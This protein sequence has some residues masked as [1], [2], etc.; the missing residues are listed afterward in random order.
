MTEA[1]G[2][3]PI[4]TPTTVEES[5]ARTLWRVVV[6]PRAAMSGLGRDPHAS[7]KGV[8]LLAIVSAVYT[9]ILAAFLGQGYAAAAP[10]ALPLASDEQY[11]AVVY[12][13]PIGLFIR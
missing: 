3:R 8:V 5:F 7:R 4:P 10:S 12:A 6:S 2:P 13:L 1:I 11:G 9:P